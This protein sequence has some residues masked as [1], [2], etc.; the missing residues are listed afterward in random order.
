M[1]RERQRTVSMVNSLGSPRREW[2][3]F[4]WFFLSSS[5]ININDSFVQFKR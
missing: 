1:L 4:S 3:I 5:D 2:T